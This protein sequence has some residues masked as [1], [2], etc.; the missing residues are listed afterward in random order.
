V[1][2]VALVTMGAWGDLFPFVGVG[3][4][5]VARGHEGERASSS[6]LTAALRAARRTP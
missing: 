4:A 1:G 6:A 3:R 5:L 2:A